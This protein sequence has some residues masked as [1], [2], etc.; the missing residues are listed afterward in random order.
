MEERTFS[1]ACERPIAT[2]AVCKRVFALDH[3]V[4]GRMRFRV[5]WAACSG[6]HGLH[7]W[8]HAEDPH[9]S[10]QIVGE[11]VEAHLGPDLVESSG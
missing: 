9:H 7:E 1:D 5:T 4:I 2:E 11:D 6:C 8:P 10:L 3:S